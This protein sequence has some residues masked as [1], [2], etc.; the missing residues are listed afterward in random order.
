MNEIQNELMHYGVL[1]MKWGV[2]RYQNKDG[3]LT[4]AGKK[5]VSKEYKKLNTKAIKNVEKTAQKRYVDAYNQTADEY[6]NGKIAEFNKKNNPK[7]PKYEEKY[8]EKFN[9]D[10]TDRYNK[11]LLVDLEKDVN[12]KKG[13]ALCDKYAM[14]TFDDLARDNEEILRYVKK[15]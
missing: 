10:L 6:N 2:R 5:K 12:F 4:S 11:M 13:K 15:S 8:F 7:D 1:G 3:S 9:K 14:V